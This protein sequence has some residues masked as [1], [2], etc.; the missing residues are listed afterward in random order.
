DTV[1]GGDGN[2]TL[3]GS[4]GNDTIIGGAGIDTYLFGLGAGQDTIDNTH[5]DAG[6]DRVL[7]G[8]GIAASGVTYARSGNDLLVLLGGA[9]DQLT[10][11]NWFLGAQYQL[12]AFVLADGVTAVPV[13]LSTIG[14]A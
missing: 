9:V 6:V 3:T 2:D 10:I 4:G 7:F 12:G 14:T 11:H 8:A 1:D 13:A 5:S